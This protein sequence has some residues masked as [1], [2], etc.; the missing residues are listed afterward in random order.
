[1]D[2]RLSDPDDLH[3]YITSYVAMTPPNQVVKIHGYHSSTT[4]RNN[5]KETERVVDFDIKLSMQAYLP[6]GGV[7]ENGWLPKLAA[8]RDRVYRGSWKKNVAEGHKEDVERYEYERDLRQWCEHFC[9]S[10]ARLR[11]FRVKQDVTGL[12]TDYLRKNL[13]TLIRSTNYK[14]HLQITFPIEGRYVDIYNPH[15]INEWRTNW[16][17][18]LFYISMLWIITWPI[19]IFA[20]RWWT[21]YSVDW[22]FSW[23]E[24]TK[25]K[26]SVTTEPGWYNKHAALIRRLAMSNFQGDATGLPLEVQTE[27]RSRSTGN[28]NVDN[29]VS[30]LQGGIQVWNTIQRGAGRDV[31]SWGADS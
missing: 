25:K 9:A 16:V 12:D 27:A 18:Y 4:Y 14:G 29:A 24:Q 8:N 10:K 6:L 2:A 15:P 1:M 20:T 3:S 11:A 28:A 23:V 31:D 5:K 30:L 7:L 22:R 19:L 13:E 26:Y 17:R 21:V